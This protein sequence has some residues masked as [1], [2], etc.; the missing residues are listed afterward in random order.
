MKKQKLK[1]LKKCVTK[2]KDKNFL[3]LGIHDNIKPIPARP[4]NHP[5]APIICDLDKLLNEIL[6]I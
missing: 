2:M 6:Q 4:E 1:I 3:I 5:S